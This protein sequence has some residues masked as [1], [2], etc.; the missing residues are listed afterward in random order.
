MTQIRVAHGTPQETECWPYKTAEPFPYRGLR[1]S[2]F[3]TKVIY[4]GQSSQPSELLGFGP[5]GADG[6]LP[7]ATGLLVGLLVGLQRMT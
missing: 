7:G 6:I 2:I 4:K 5:V 3:F 1:N